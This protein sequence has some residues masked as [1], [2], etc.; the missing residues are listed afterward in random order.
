[1]RFLKGRYGYYEQVI[2]KFIEA[3]DNSIFASFLTIG[4]T[5]PEEPM[6]KRSE[7]PEHP[8]RCPWIFRLNFLSRVTRFLNVLQDQKGEKAT[9]W[10]F[11]AI[12]P[13]IMLVALQRA[14]IASTKTEGTGMKDSL[15]L[16]IKSSKYKKDF[17]NCRKMMNLYCDDLNELISKFNKNLDIEFKD[18]HKEKQFITELASRKAEISVKMKDGPKKNLVFFLPREN[19]NYFPKKRKSATVKTYFDGNAEKEEKLLGF[20]GNAKKFQ[21]EARAQKSF[22]TWVK[23][24]EDVALAL[25]VSIFVLC[26]II[27]LIIFFTSPLTNTSTS[28]TLAPSTSG[29]ACGPR[30]SFRNSTEV[31]TSE[32]ST[33]ASSVS[34]P[35][36][37]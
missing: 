33:L 31:P 36:D 23:Y 17:I 16:L 5:D 8:E 2:E 20:I 3:K 21:D 25:T 28:G 14:F 15:R 4:F 7:D 26:L 12:E 10:I 32:S 37:D 34:E 18:Q 27:N 22:P 24:S 9:E 11:S 19:S 1:M 6:I 30:F 13:N 35:R 29:L